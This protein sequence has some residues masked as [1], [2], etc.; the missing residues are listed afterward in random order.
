MKP[1]KLSSEN[2]RKAFTLIELIVVL[3][4]LVGLAGVLIPAVTSM[5]IRTN[6]S[7]SA[8]NVSEIA[9]AVQR[10]EAIYQE[11]PND[12]DSLVTDL[13]AGT[14][15]NTLNS[16]LTT[17]FPTVALSADTLA[18]LN[19]A[20][21]TNVGVHAVDD[22]TFDAPTSTALA[23]T[24]TL[25]GLSTGHQQT[26][27]L[28]SAA[29]AAAGKYVVFGIGGRCEMNGRTMV[30]APVHF[31]RDAATNPELQ[32][33]RFVAVFQVTDGTDALTRA[34]FVGVVAPDGSGMSTQMSGYFT[35]IINN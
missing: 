13:T 31:P 14:A 33:S 35:S 6:R 26:L 24:S 17:L 15:L 21:I 25:L 20:G 30:D 23:A 10:Y 2:R 7:T 4:I 28:E 34:K 9:G 32:Y 3:T 1:F 29:T 22:T 18:T 27:G 16:A 19:N 8:A 5:V 11:Y 12:M